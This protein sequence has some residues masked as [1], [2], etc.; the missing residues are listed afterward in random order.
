MRSSTFSCPGCIPSHLPTGSYISRRARAMSSA[1]DARDCESDCAFFLICVSSASLT[2][3]KDHEIALWVSPLCP[4]SPGAPPPPP[5]PYQ[6]SS[7]SSNFCDDG[8]VNQ[9][10]CECALKCACFVQCMSASAVPD[11]AQALSLACRL[12]RV[13]I[14]CLLPAYERVPQTDCLTCAVHLPYKRKKS[15][16]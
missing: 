7:T 16:I 4:T 3:G 9:D 10:A 5:H 13:H 1:S 14:V 11:D 15:N 2:P 12:L 8:M 6:Y